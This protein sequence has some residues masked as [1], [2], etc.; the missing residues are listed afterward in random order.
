MP[1]APAKPTL[2]ELA[3]TRFADVSNAESLL[4]KVV[5]KGE[6]ADCTAAAPLDATIRGDR[7]VWLCTN[8]D[9]AAL[10][11]YRGISII[12]VT[13]EGIVDLEWA[14]L[15]F[16]LR[17][18]NCIFKESILLANSCLESLSLLETELQDLQARQAVIKH[19]LCLKAARARG[20]V[21]LIRAKIGGDLDCDGGNFGPA[22]HVPV[23]TAGAT[24]QHSP[25]PA[26][27]AL[28]AGGAEIDG[29]VF[30]R[31]GFKATRS[32][33]FAS[34]RV[35]GDLDCT[36]GHFESSDNE[37]ALNAN[38]AQIDG[39]VYLRKKGDNTPDFRAKG[40]VVL[41][42]ARIGQSL[43]CDDAHFERNGQAE[44]AVDADNVSIAGAAFFRRNTMEVNGIISFNHALVK[45]IFELSNLK[46]P[47]K[48]KL[49]LR[50]ARI[51]TLLHSRES[52]PVQGRLLVD[53]L[54]YDRIHD[55]ACPNAKAQLDWLKLQPDIHSSQPFEQLAAA[56]RERGLEE[57]ARSVMIAKNEE[58]RKRLRGW[59]WR[60]PNNWISSAFE[61]CW[62]KGLGRIIAYGYHPWNAFVLSLVVVAIGS[63]LFGIGY[64]GKLVA[65]TGDKAYVIEKV[66]TRRSQKNG[67][68]QI[69]GDY[70]KFNAIVYS[71]ETFVPLVKFG[72]ADHWA[73]NANCGE[74]I[75]LGIL[76]LPRPGMWLRY[77]LWLHIVAGWVLTTLWVGGLTGLV[78]SK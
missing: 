53:G 64:N 34:A 22:A 62:Y 57:D 59:D 29:F 65:P 74:S 33:R 17:A 27:Q 16:P 75:R 21:N 52:W 20:E 43:E 6:D 35:G 48:L 51:G 28:N 12:G 68:L 5:P 1:G 14:N 36:G 67:T 77:Y 44:D 55:N 3:A 13:I 18:R 15:S 9:A 58:R 11:T 63:F 30:L 49:D 32:V 26:N 72:I 37:P 41:R 60:Q 19:D 61:W 23:A 42:N 45:Q 10:V 47:E 4:F 66:G 8:S 56:L 70:P 69:S 76:R 73:P 50:F 25:Q 39:F 54:V 71:I 31:A 40:T 46:Q 2:F 24:Q 7:L 78:K 38:G